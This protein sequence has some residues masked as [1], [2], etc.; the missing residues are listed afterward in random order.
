[1]ISTVDHSTRHTPWLV[2]MTMPSSAPPLQ[3][4]FLNGTITETDIDTAVTRLFAARWDI[5]MYYYY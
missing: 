4:S 5:I 3:D 2:T 1:M